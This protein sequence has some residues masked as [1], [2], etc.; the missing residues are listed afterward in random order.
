MF[1]LS[2]DRT[3]LFGVSF[4]VDCVVGLGA[5]LGERQRTFIWALEQLRTFGPITALSNLYENPAVG[6][7][8]QPD[9]LNGA[10]RL[11]TELDGERLL[12]GLQRIELMAGRERKVPWGPRTLDLDLLWVSGQ[13]IDTER[14]TVPHPRLTER[15]FAL[16]PLVEVAPM[17]HCP[18][19]QQSYAIL[20]EVVETS[21]LRLAATASGPPWKWHSQRS[22][23]RTT[24]ALTCP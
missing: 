8:P 24:T 6:G 22:R 5:N 18:I 11:S 20:L 7:P 14:L 13:A 9:Y 3:S 2:P 19:T 21:C 1:A 10:V 23:N 16:K 4:S 17:A 15:A 12:T